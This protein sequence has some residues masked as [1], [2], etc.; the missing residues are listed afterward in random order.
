MGDPQAPDNLELGVE[1]QVWLAV[2]A[3]RDAPVSQKY[4]YHKQ[5]RSAHPAASYVY[6]QNQLLD[7]CARL[8]GV[9]LPSGVAP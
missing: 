5:I 8:T 9:E 7:A 6:F 4:I 2:S 1:T 3:E